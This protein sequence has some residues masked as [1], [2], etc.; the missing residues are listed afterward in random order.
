MKKILTLF[1]FGV[2]VS[3][4]SNA[5]YTETKDITP[6]GFSGNFEFL[7]Y[8]KTTKNPTL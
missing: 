5:Q 3:F 1:V 4:V 6:L 7:Q 2:L 8:S